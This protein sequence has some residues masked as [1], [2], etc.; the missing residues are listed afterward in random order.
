MSVPTSPSR[1]YPRAHIPMVPLA[2]RTVVHMLRR[3]AELQP[4]RIAVRDATGELDYAELLDRSARAGGALA[5][6]GVRRGDPVL[7]MLENNIEHVLAW[8]GSSWIGALEVPVNTALMAPQLAFIANDSEAHVLV[9]EEQYLPRLREVA[10]QLPHLRHVV[11]RG[12]AEAAEGIGFTVHP[13]SV[14]TEAEPVPAVELRP[15]D[16]AGIMYTSGTT[17]TPKGV[18]VTHA[19][20]YGR[21]G[22]LGPGAPQPGDTCLI[23]LPIYHVIGQCRGLYNT[24]IAGGT[25]VL[26]ERF[27]ASRFWDLCRKH[28]VT[29]V[30]IVGVM[31]GYLLA[32]PERDDDRDN[33]VQRIV[34]GTTIPEVERFRE[35]FDVPELYVS[36]GLTEAGGVLVGTAEAAGCGLLRDDFEARLVDEHDVEVPDG[37]VGELVLRPLEP[38]TTMAGYFKRPEATNERLRNLWLHTGDLMTR[39]PD[40]VYVFVGRLA[41]R[42][43]TRGENIAPPAVEEQI[44]GHPDVAEC[45]VVGVAPVEPDAAPGDQ[46]VLAVLVARAG[47]ELDLPGL[48]GFLAARLPYFAVPRF[49]RVVDVLPRTDSTHRV[50]RTELAAAGTA[51]AWDRVAA[52]VTVRR[53]G[54]VAAT[55]ARGAQAGRNDTRDAGGNP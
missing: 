42:I 41:E 24:L 13:A 6:L 30:P 37:E 21:N 18:L 40:G 10:D 28:D 44:L 47:A 46:E 26:E 29:F 27:S 7:L 33:P 8:F 5:A 36:Y 15:G 9:I 17:G 1:E 48:V 2:E 51:D 55:G 19:Q 12:N 52:G 43:R 3:G 49:F 14:L 23:V 39:R 11:V 25:A 16:L 54:T 53:D 31:A 34:L 35:R 20:T 22:P 32:Q 45:A 4:H 38:W 50:Q